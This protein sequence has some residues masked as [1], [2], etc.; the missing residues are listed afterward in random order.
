MPQEPLCRATWDFLVP[1][2]ML[3]DKYDMGILGTNLLP[4]LL[5]D[6]PTTLEKWD[7]VDKRAHSIVLATFRQ[8]ER[9]PALPSADD[10]LPDPAMAVKFGRAHPAARDVLPAAFYHL[11][12]LS[13]STDGD[14]P[15]GPYDPEFFR[16]ADYNLM[17]SEDWRRVVRGQ[18]NIRAWLEWLSRTWPAEC[19]RTSFKDADEVE[20]EYGEGTPDPCKIYEWW[21]ENFGPSILRIGTK[22]VVDVL[23]Q[24]ESFRIV[25]DRIDRA[26]TSTDEI[27]YGCQ[28]D[29]VKRLEDSRNKFWKHLPFFFGLGAY[30]NWGKSWA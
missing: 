28:R 3:T 23:G 11:S 10:V 9:N 1:V 22:R 5:E 12:R 15:F 16:S 24:L 26:T 6:W 7:D 4:K 25:V 17:T 2:L 8:R 18:A 29:V 21:N 30:P 19:S 14:L 13:S 20:M 27:C